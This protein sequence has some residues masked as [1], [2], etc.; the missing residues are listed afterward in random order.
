VNTILAG[1]RFT[2][3]FPGIDLD[4]TAGDAAVTIKGTC[5]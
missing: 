5:Q 3:A 1:F 2:T 4:G